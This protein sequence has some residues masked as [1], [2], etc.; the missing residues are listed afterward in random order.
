LQEAAA[1]R[2]SLRRDE[3]HQDAKILARELVREGKLT[4]FQA[5]AVYQG[6]LKGLVLGDYAILDKIGSGGM[7]DVYRA[8]HRRMKRI[9]AVKVL[10]DA[11]TKSPDLLRRFYREV[12][13]AAKLSHPNIVAAYDASESDG[14]HYL[15]MEFVD[16]Q[17]LSAVIKE[18]GAIPV[19]QAVECILQ[20]AR[21]LEYAHQQGIVHRDIKPGNLLL[22]REGTVKILDMGLARVAQS[23]ER[24]GIDDDTAE[25][26]TSSGQVLGTCDYMAPEQAENSH[27]ADPRSDIYSLGCTLYRL[28]TGRAPYKSDSIINTL[29]AHRQSPIPSLNEARDDVP[30]GLDTVFRK[31]MA[32]EP[33]A[34]YQTMTEVIGAL[35]ECL[36]TDQPSPAAAPADRS[37]PA[38]AETSTDDALQSFLNHPPG[39]APTLQHLAKPARSHPDHGSGIN[40]AETKHGGGSSVTA[41]PASASHVAADSSAAGNSSSSAN[42]EPASAVTVDRTRLWLTAGACVSSLLLLIGL[43]MVFLYVSRPPADPL[44]AGQQTAEAEDQVMEEDLAAAPADAREQTDAQSENATSGDAAPLPPPIETPAETQ[45]PINPPVVPSSGNL[46]LLWPAS[47]RQDARLLIDNQTV[48]IQTAVDPADNNQLKLPLPAG[49][50]SL[51]IDRRGFRPFLADVQT[52]ADQDATLTPTW[53][54]NEVPPIPDPD[55][56][57]DISSGEPA[58]AQEDQESSPATMEP[59]VVPPPVNPALVQYRQL[60]QQYAARLQPVEALVAQWDFAG[61]VEA[62]AAVRFDQQEFSQRLAVRTDQIRRMAALKQKLI[63]WVNQADSLTKRDLALSGVGT[64]RVTQA[65]ES[66]LT[67]VSSGD[68]E[69]QHRWQDL[70]PKATAK[71]LELSIDRTAADDWLAASLIAATAGDP[72]LTNRLLQQVAT[73]GVQANG[74]LCELAASAFSQILQMIDDERFTEA[75]KALSVLQ[76][77]CA[78]TA[79]YTTQQ[80]VIQ[81]A[82]DVVDRGL[83]EAEA[84]VLFARAVQLLEDS[85]LFE[86]R[87]AVQQLQ[88]QYPDAA[89]LRDTDRSPD[90][91]D[92]QAAVAKL[93][94]QLTVR[95]DGQGNFRTIQEAIDAAG[96][97]TLIEIQDAG[98]YN[99]NLIITPDK[100]GLTIRGAADVWPLIT[101]SGPKRDFPILVTADAPRTTLQRVA[102]VHTAPAGTPMRCLSIQE[103]SVRLRSAIVYMPVSPEAVWISGSRGRCEIEDSLVLADIMVNGARL[104]AEDTVFVSGTLSVNSGSCELRHVTANCV[105]R[106]N[107]PAS[108]LLDSI[109]TTIDVQ[110]GRHRIEHCDVFSR[111]PFQGQAAPGAGCFNVNPKLRDPPK[112]DFR[113]MDNSPC[114]G[115]ASDGGD[116]GCRETPELQAVCDT[117]ARLAERGVFQ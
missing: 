30:P 3:L 88:S 90:W 76:A 58:D 34:R 26:L 35:E 103:G 84:V 72:D 28:L 33:Q 57:E 82:H 38:S 83:R 61:A 13:A 24:V 49:P 94:A 98:P 47:Q 79:W 64:D 78:K 91:A 106:L 40:L 63:A 112:F 39:G 11:A 5:Q 104:S 95:R 101:S 89:V 15:V 19:K 23:V 7:G 31:M 114:R 108:V 105:V 14:I 18:H 62:I 17:D 21:G 87:D 20:A 85:E 52:R 60:D 36:R 70:G 111:Q 10:P 113:L 77:Q 6:N 1:L 51:W 42:A 41:K 93:G 69:Q 66:G 48:D 16:G 110:Q 55:P 75:D 53:I 67:A 8:R 50:H 56:S 25:E 43:G 73:L 37:A 68:R 86:L 27:H 96:P 59:E 80:S 22:H 117:A 107:N 74:H 116:V 45:P 99:E 115:R 46:V 100:A 65:D 54:Q 92:L 102:L 81:A 71:L 29:M 44:L 12:E 32:K 4:K 2:A 9:V 97:N 109:L